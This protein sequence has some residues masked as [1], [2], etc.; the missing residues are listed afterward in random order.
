MPSSL[1]IPENQ[2]K[3]LID[4]ALEEDIAGGD[5]T[6]RILVP[7]KLETKAI[8]LAKT[9]GVLAGI[10]IACLVFIRVDPEIKIEILLPDGSVLK[11]GDII[12]CING[13]ARS[14]LRA[15]RVVL[16]FVQ[17]LSGIATKTH[18]FVSLV[19]D[20]PVKILDTRKTTPGFRLLE[21]YAVKIGGGTNH[22][23]NMSD[24]VLIKDNHLMMVRKQGMTMGQAVKTAKKEAPAGLRVEVETT[25]LTEVKEAVAAGADIIMFDNMA[26]AMMRKAV[27]LLPPGIKSEASGGINLKTLRKVAETGVDYISVGAL[28][29]SAEALDISLEL[30]K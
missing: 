24:G 16:N 27:K 12:A 2:V 8:L 25:N 29:H 1:N 18:Q 14:I 7:A 15:E 30:V 6:S 22:R 10:D 5:I 11:K 28:T 3:Q 4:L 23:L 26:P 21:K 19:Q 13:K 9:D 17:K 20:L